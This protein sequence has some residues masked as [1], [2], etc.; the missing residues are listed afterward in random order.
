M[1]KPKIKPHKTNG[2][3][4]ARVAAELAEMAAR[5]NRGWKQIGFS[6]FRPSVDINVPPSYLMELQGQRNDGVVFTI[7]IALDKV[8]IDLIPTP[9]I[10]LKVTRDA[11]VNAV[12][13]LQTF[14]ECS[15]TLEGS[16][17]EHR[18]N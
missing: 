8:K 4:P 2:A 9:A 12:L 15:C 3:A 17:Q 5:R 18:S 7:K 10:A 16:C 1:G 11:I 6:T 14:L 13:Q